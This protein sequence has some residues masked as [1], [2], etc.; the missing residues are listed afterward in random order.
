MPGLMMADMIAAEFIYSWIVGGVLFEALV[1]GKPLLTY[2][3]DAM[4]SKDYESLYPIYNARDSQQ[5]AD[6]L[7]D[8]VR[9]NE[10][11]VAMGKI[12][13][14]WYEENVVSKVV[15]KYSNYLEGRA[16]QIGKK[17]W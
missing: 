10:R 11:G 4:H 13:K 16:E 14:K 17:S 8:Y 3:D 1:A 7:N 12:G 5:I 15:R 9:E 6:H 2:R